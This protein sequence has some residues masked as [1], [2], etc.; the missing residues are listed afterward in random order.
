MAAALLTGLPVAILYAVVVDY[1]IQGL[2]GV[3]SG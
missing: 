2:T 1:F 3:A